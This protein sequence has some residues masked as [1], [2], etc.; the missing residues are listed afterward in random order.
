[1]ITAVRVWMMREVAGTGE[2]KYWIRRWGPHAEVLEPTSLRDEMRAE[3]S[4]PRWS[5]MDL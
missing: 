1:M 2:I 3:T 5:G 4:S